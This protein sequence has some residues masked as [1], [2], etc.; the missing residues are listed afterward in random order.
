MGVNERPVLLI[1]GR[2]INLARSPEPRAADRKS[3][4]LAASMDLPEAAI[5]MPI[6]QPVY[7]LQP[8]SSLRE[9]HPHGTGA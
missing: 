3:S 6:L 7:R 5:A 9:R 1:A 8:R 4:V 2:G